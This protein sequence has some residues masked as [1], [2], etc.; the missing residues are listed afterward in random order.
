M[1]YRKGLKCN[2]PTEVHRGLKIC[3][4]VL[5]TPAILNAIPP[6]ITV[7]FS[8]IIILKMIKSG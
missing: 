4:T 5:L 8:S 7:C 6:K 2:K 3:S 1:L